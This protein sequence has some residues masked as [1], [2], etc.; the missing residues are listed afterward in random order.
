MY[1]QWLDQPLS[2]ARA[3]TPA[4]TGLSLA[5]PGAVTLVQRFD[6]ALRLNVHAHTLALDGVYVGDEPGA[7]LDFHPLPW[8]APADVLNVAGR[9]AARIRQVLRAHG[10]LV[11]QGQAD[12]QLLEPT[13]FAAEQ[14]A[15]LSCY[16]ASVPRGRDLFGERAGS[17]TLVSMAYSRP[18]PGFAPRW[19]LKAP[20][21]LLKSRNS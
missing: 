3:Q 15:L 21:S 17:P 10:R 19:C 1:A 2:I 4:L 5:H 12:E 6:S 18:T 16:R 8:L 9:T 20:T 11:E 7:E 14:P 13:D